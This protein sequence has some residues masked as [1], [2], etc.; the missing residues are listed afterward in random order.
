MG[1]MSEERIRTEQQDDEEP[2]LNEH[3]LDEVSG[4]AKEVSR[5]NSVE[6]QYK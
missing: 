3:E 6:Q 5:K 2:E 4:G 1:T